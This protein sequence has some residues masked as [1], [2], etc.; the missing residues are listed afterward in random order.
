MVIEAISL[1]RA[2]EIGGISGVEVT[3]Q[4][5]SYFRTGSIRI[6]VLR[7]RR[8]NLRFAQQFGLERQKLVDR[9]VEAL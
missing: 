3:S 9:N 7:W 8:W 4:R 6:V 2:V 5:F 1:E